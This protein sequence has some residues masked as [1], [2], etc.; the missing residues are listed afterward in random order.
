LRRLDAEGHDRARRGDR[1]ADDVRHRRPARRAAREDRLGVERR[2]AA[3]LGHGR[4]LTAP[5][6]SRAVGVTWPKACSA[7]DV[8]AWAA[9]MRPV[10]RPLGRQAFA[11]SAPRVRP[12]YGAE[13]SAL[14]KNRPGTGRDSGS[15]AAG[16][17]QTTYQAPLRP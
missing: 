11:S 15:R 10:W 12:P 8:W 6:R 17:W 1:D 2:R 13:L 3:G 16:P 14:T 9:G 4:K 7:S 5:G